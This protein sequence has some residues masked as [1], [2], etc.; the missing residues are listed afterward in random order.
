MT[1]TAVPGVGMALYRE[2]G[3]EGLAFLTRAAGNRMA[4]IAGVGR[5]SPGTPKYD[6]NFVARPV[7]CLH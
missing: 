2:H 4:G 1:T 6:Q 3:G 5:V 7:G